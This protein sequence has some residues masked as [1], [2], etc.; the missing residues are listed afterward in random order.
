MFGI[1]S[2]ELLLIFV[3]ALVVLG[4]KSI[5]TIAKTIGKAMGDFRRASTEF[6][7]TMNVEAEMEDHEMRKKEAEKELFNSDKDNTSNKVNIAKDAKK[8]AQSE[9]D[10]SE[11]QDLNSQD[12][13]SPSANVVD[14]VHINGSA[15]EQIQIID[16]TIKEETQLDKA[17]RKAE[18]EANSYVESQ[19]KDMPVN[20]DAQK[21]SKEVA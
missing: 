4:P 21:K 9:P 17:V 14:N 10:K 5:P 13:A 19:D 15:N 7:R 16:T 3:V 8:T 20:E 1:G 2:T 6:Q 18:A 11:N 12:K